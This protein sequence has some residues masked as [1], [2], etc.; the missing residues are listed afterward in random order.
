MKKDPKIKT[1]AQAAVSEVVEAAKA[2]NVEVTKAANKTT[3]EVAEKVN[4]LTDTI[5]NN[6]KTI[7]KYALYG[8]A[9]LAV[10]VLLWIIF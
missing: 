8:A 4:S 10:I 6:S 9:A 5:T 1:T 3:I 7:S 2:V